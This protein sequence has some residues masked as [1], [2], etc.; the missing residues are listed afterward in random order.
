MPD[1]PTPSFVADFRSAAPYVHAFRGRTFVVVF[2]GEVIDAGQ[3]QA[4][5]HDLALLNSLGVRLVL[6]HGAR[7][8]IESRL[9]QRGLALRYEQGWRVTDGGSLAAVKEAVGVLRLEI[10]GTL[11]MGLAQTPMAGANLRVVSGNFVTARPLGVLGGVDYAYTGAVRRVDTEGIR[12]QLDNGNM[13]L[14]SPLGYS[15]TGELFNLRAEDV[16]EATSVALGADKLLFLMDS[17][18]IRTGGAFRD[19]LGPG[20][21]QALLDSGA[22]LTEEEARHLRTAVNACR[23]GVRRVHLLSRSADGAILQ[24]LFTRDGVGTLVASDPFEAIRAATPDDLGGI[25]ELVRPLAEAGILLGRGQEHLES[26]LDCYWVMERDGLVVGTAALYA[27]PEQEA[28][29][30]ACLAVHPDYRD[31]GRGERLLETVAEAARARG[32][33]RLFVLTTQTAHWFRERGFQPGDPEA[34]PPARRALYDT[35]RCSKVLERPL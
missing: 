1:S 30:L 17:P 28:G 20:E 19:E 32:L 13:V 5:A 2:G 15:P 21:A 34:P 16:A 24:E 26:E 31:G 25:Q 7:P 11:S 33:G 8:Q 9:A 27:Y 6:V 3:F 4:L 22:E 12:G 14:L 10:E 23:A 18:G 35:G 29:E